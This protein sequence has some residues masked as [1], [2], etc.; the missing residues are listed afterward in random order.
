MRQALLAI[1]RFDTRTQINCLYLQ[2]VDDLRPEVDVHG[3]AV[4]D[5]S[6]ALLERVL[7]DGD[8]VEQ[9]VKGAQHH[10]QLQGKNTTCWTS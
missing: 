5:E 7:Q 9:G 1:Q 2:R 8:G 4:G 3:R 6:E 10:D